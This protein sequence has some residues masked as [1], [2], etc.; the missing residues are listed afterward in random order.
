MNRQ[1][2]PSARASILKGSASSAQSAS[3]A[4]RLLEQKKE[5]E[6]LEILER[7]S[8]SFVRRIEQLCEDSEVMADAAVG[9]HLCAFE[10][11]TDLSQS[12]ST[13]SRIGPMA[14]GISPAK[15]VRY[16]TSPVSPAQL[17]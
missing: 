17:S 2:V 5:Y 15:H 3:A 11:R 12:R 6:A 1:S 7:L 16:D 13:G 10:H 14:R 8:Q 4:A 9:E